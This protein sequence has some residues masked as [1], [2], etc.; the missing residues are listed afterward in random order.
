[1]IESTAVRYFRMVTECGSIKQAAASLRIAPSAISRQVQ[2]LEEELAV[3]LFERGARGMNLTD[4][5]HVLYRYAI[6]NRT[7]LDGL[8][9]RV[10]EFDSLRRGQVKI[11]TV[12]GMLASFLPDFFVDLSRDYPGISMSVTAVGS[13]DVAEMVG[14]NDVD[15]GLVFGRAPRRD[16]IELA[17]MRQ[18]VHLIVAPDHP[19]AGRASC[20]MKDLAGLRVVVPDP[21]F[22][23]RQELDKACAQAHVHLEVCNETN[24]LA[25][26][27][28]I[29][30]RTELATFLPRDTAM[31]SIQAGALVAVPLH[32]RRLEAT[33][34][35]LVQLAA[36]TASPSTRLVAERL[37][38]KMKATEG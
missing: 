15:L 31:P 20:T 6:E 22:G 18:S 28:T 36:R 23:I 35:T 2:G 21:S 9:S 4:A 19:L 16:L 34:V 7:Q 30:A 38:E 13:R 24:S 12:E 17:R 32:D 26:A 3:K 25:F 10:E 1:M 14:Q 27:Q 33:Q 37:I 29:V 5:G 8:R 11:A